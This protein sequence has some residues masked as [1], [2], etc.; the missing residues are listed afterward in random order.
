MHRR[1]WGY[2]SALAT[3]AF[4][5]AGAIPAAAITPTPPTPTPMTDLVYTPLE[6]CRIIDTRIAGEALVVGTPRDFKV[7]GT[8]LQAQGGSPHGCGVPVSRAYAAMINVVAV[9][10]AGAGN[11]RAWAYTGYATTPPN[12]SI[13]N[14][15]A[16]IN[17][18]NGISVRVCD[19]SMPPGTCPFDIIVQADVN[20]T[21]L[22]ADVL[23]YFNAPPPYTAGFGLTLAGPSV[24][25]FRA[26][27]SV[28]QRRVGGVCAA[29]NSIRAIAED[30]TVTCEPDDVGITDIVTAPNS[31]LTGSVSDGVASLAVDTTAFNGTTPVVSSNQAVGVSMTPG[32]TA[33]LRTVT[34]TVPAGAT[35]G[36]HIAVIG[37]ATGTCGAGSCAAGTTALGLIG[38]TPDSVGLPLNTKTWSATAG[39]QYSTT[40][41]IDQ[42]V[43]TGPGTYTYYLRNTCTTTATGNC[44]VGALSAMAWFIPR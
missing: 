39:G 43:V 10:P 4:M 7:A 28:L 41:A 26:N 5:A 20:G 36:G 42:F 33:T 21:H 24:R 16:G 14:Y 3:V 23:G 22:V 12:A 37:M 40:G 6:P 30:G 8:D 35:N 31:G 38:W 19:V 9:Q 2:V 34:V 15:T 29:G 27:P 18:A 25:E 44:F 32:D 17:I 11:L 13:I 1:F